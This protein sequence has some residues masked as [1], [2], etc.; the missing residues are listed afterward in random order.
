[1]LITAAGFFSWLL[2]SLLLGFNQ[3]V[4]T[5]FTS[6]KQL[7][8]VFAFL[9]GVSSSFSYISTI[10]K[11]WWHTT[12]RT[13]LVTHHRS[14]LNPWWWHNA[15]LT[16]HGYYTCLYSIPETAQCD[17]FR[18]WAIVPLTVL[19]SLMQSLRVSRSL[20]PSHVVSMSY[21]FPHSLMQSHSLTVSSL[22]CSQSHN[23]MVS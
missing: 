9:L 3:H 4:I 11:Q 6:L 12:R 23:H 14:H 13:P 19:H 17:A 5:F 1:M 21:A 18:Y 22:T 10:T 20:I 7:S 15:T 2:W 8:Q 16:G